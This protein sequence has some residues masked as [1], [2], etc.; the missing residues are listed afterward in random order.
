MLLVDPNDFSKA[1]FWSSVG[2]IFEILG[3]II[4]VLGTI[5]GVWKSL[6]DDLKSQMA[7]ITSKA[8]KGSQETIKSR[9]RSV[10]A[11]CQTPK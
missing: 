3:T 7:L 6:L 10:L 2:T 5:L 1:A 4:G 8:S 9:P 11:R